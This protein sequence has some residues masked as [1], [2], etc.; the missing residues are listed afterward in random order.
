VHVDYWG[1]T[2]KGNNWTNT[3]NEW[4]KISGQ[5]IINFTVDIYNN[6]Q[7]YYFSILNNFIII[8]Q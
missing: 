8:I 7:P 3:A 6:I 1:K 5:T 4:Q 2:T